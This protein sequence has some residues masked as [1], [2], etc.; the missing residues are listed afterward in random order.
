MKKIAI[1]GSTGHIAK[2][3]IE[4][5]AGKHEL[6]LYSRSKDRPLGLFPH[7]ACDVVIN[8]IG[9]GEK[10]WKDR[11]QIFRVTETFDNMVLD[12]LLRYPRTLY[13][14]FSSAA[15]FGHYEAPVDSGTKAV[16]DLNDLP[17]LSLYGI[18][19]INSEAKHRSLR[20]LN[21]ID[22]RIFSYFS[23][24][25]APDAVCL[26]S[27]VVSAIRTGRELI[28]SP[29]D[30]LRDYIHPKDLAALVECCLSAV[31]PAQAG[32]AAPFLNKAF[33]AYS[34][35]PIGKFELLDHFA[36][37]RG[38]KYQIDEN[39]KETSPTGPKPNL[40]SNNLAA[41]RL[42]YAPRYSSMNTIADESEALLGT[43]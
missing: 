21:I 4:N 31:T 37:W 36:R 18:S 14:S 17:D 9:V 42:G 19:K 10:L 13:I 7:E 12:Y 6:A 3:L 15:V 41:H 35:F 23:R 43:V 22:I 16:L 8:C 11:F 29:H 34:L 40:Y 38:L 5:L 33:D 30:F 39:W 32:I 20:E 24:H 26:M 28:T 2:G 25:L 27:E 1:L